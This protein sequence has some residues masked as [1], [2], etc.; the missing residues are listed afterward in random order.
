MFCWDLFDFVTYYWLK[1]N[2][3]PSDA[4]VE[5]CSEEISYTETRFVYL[6]NISGRADDVKPVRYVLYVFVCKLL[7]QFYS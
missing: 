1:L 7:L 4:F 3:S 2:L 6:V 5:F